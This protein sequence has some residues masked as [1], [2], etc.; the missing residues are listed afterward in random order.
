MDGRRRDLITRVA[1]MYYIE[2]KSQSE[3]ASALKM[4][5]SNVS[6]LLKASRDQGIVE[7]RIH[8]NTSLASILREKM[9]RHFELK[10]C[11][12]VETLE[13]E[14]RTK[15]SLGQAGAELLKHYLSDGISLGIS[16]GTSVFY[17]V[18]A[19]QLSQPYKVD[20][21]QLMGGVGAR[22][23]SI[24]GYRLAHALSGRFEGACYVLQAP[25][26]VQSGEFRELLLKEP[27]IQLVFRQFPNVNIGLIGL[28]SNYPESSSLVRAG[29]LSKNETKYLV[30]Q[31]A[32]GNI[33]GRHIDRDGNACDIP[34]NDRIVGIELEQFASIPVRIGLA[35]GKE[36]G[37]ILLGALK[38]GHINCVV[39]DESVILSLMEIVEKEA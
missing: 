28:G 2:D 21:V 22:D 33:M 6:K 15:M 1:K 38:G 39:A 31:G 37:E 36:K 34:L 27:D 16:W 7:I 29:Y 12:I 14:E 35:S 24:D 32:V 18:R 5:R 17:A 3:I 23:L 4:S 11:V 25:L 26:I 13:T 8:E 9:E 20:I 10:S 30:D 19:F